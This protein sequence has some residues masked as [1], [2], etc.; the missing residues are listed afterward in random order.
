[1]KNKY[2]ILGIISLLVCVI[3]TIF[4]DFISDDNV[5]LRFGYALGI[6][7]GAFMIIGCN[8]LYE[9]KKERREESKR[10]T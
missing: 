1:M 7:T 6:A 8:L 2:L 10:I 4:I 5:L 9:W 3:L